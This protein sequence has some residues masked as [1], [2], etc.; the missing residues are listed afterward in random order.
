MRPRRVRA[1]LVTVALLLG[2]LAGCSDSNGAGQSGSTTSSSTLERDERP[3]LQPWFDAVGDS[4]GQAANLVV[5]GDSVSEGSGLRDRL[6]RRWIDLL[7]AGLR[8]RVGAPGCPTRPG[9]YH[10]TNSLVPA[11]YGAP[12]LPDP[13]V[14]GR[15]SPA[16]TFGPGGRA[17]DLAPGASVTWQVDARSVDIGYRTRRDGGRMQI[18]IDGDSPVDG[19]AVTTFEDGAGHRRVWSSAELD[20]G[21]HTIN[22]RNDNPVFSDR[23]V[24]VT[25]LTPYR[26][27]RDRCVHVLDAS[28]SGVSARTITQTPAYLADSLSL[29]PDLLLVA[30]GFNDAASGTTPTDFGRILDTLIDQV[31]EQGYDGPILLVGWFSPQPPFEAG[32]WARYLEQMD[33]RTGRAGVGFLD[34]S[35]VLPPAD[36]SSPNYFDGVHPSAAGQVPIAESLAKALAPPPT[37][38]E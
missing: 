33:A 28:R 34:L 20:E 24:T 37:G 25:D 11:A 35:A 18:T 29:D 21:E 36:P 31:R 8:E 13:R 9:G 2:V 16:P 23:L 3:V 22:V 6:D 4:D 1:G 30:L 32:P 17:L 15:V 27:D 19:A 7:Q 12:S 10:G 14:R 26:G 38:E 5:L